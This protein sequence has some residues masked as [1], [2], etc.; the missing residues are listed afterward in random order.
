MAATA[1]MC[2]W[3]AQSS[4]SSRLT[5]AVTAVFHPTV[6]DMSIVGAS[7]V[8]GW[9]G[10]SHGCTPE[11]D[12]GSFF[13]TTG[14]CVMLSTPPA[15][16]TRSMPARMLAAAVWIGAMPDAQCR[17]CASPGISVSPRSTAA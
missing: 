11:Y 13:I 15:M 16:T 1:R 10:D 5:P 8:A 2:E 3:Y 17:L 4:C 12:P 7:G 6:I 9:L 14:L